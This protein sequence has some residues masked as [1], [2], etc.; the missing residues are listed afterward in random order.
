MTTTTAI[1]T[2][3]AGVNFR[4]R[5]EAR[6]AAFFD[7]AGWSW[8]YEPP[9]EYGYWIPDFILRGRALVP[10]EVKPIEWEPIL[11]NVSVTR[12]WQGWEQQTLDHPDLKKVLRSG[13]KEVLILGAWPI[14]DV[15]RRRRGPS[16]LGMMLYGG[17]K[18]AFDRSRTT[19]CDLAL[20]CGGYEPCRFDLSGLMGSSQYRIGGQGQRRFQWPMAGSD[21]AIHEKVPLDLEHFLH[22]EDGDLDSAWRDA[23]NR[24]QWRRG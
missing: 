17:G 16:I 22:L 14:G 9:I 20:L 10:V 11:A 6:W 13:C 23:G 5:L 3:Y 2:T 15:G 1:A 24:I 4:S 18:S 12:S 8:E 19:G 7:E 21:G